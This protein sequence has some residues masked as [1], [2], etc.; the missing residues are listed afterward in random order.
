MIEYLAKNKFATREEILTAL[1][2]DSGGTATSLFQYL[3]NCDFIQSFVPYNADEK[4]RLIRYQ[5][6]DN[7]L[8]FYYKFVAPKMREIRTKGISNYQ[9][10]L[11]I[12]P[13][14]QW[15]GYSFERWCRSHHELI[16]KKLGFED[17]EYQ[18]GAFFN[19]QP[20]GTGFQ[21]DLLFDRKDRVITVCEIKYN[22]NP[23]TTSIVSQLEKKIERIP[24]KRNQT[25]QRV[26]IATG[27]AEPSVR[28]YF[29][30]ILT[31]EDLV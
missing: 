6:A 9:K 28:N 2:M 10:A 24:K 25:I 5:I 17:V 27:R 21:I 15:L 11:P 19:K 8:Q 4:S 3:E 23:V 29:D 14:R 12:D 1:G 30:K 7:Y 16:A 18:A 20:I 22:M 26:L 13:Y 31:L